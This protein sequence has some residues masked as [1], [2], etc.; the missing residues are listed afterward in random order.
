M[1]GKGR[2]LSPVIQQ[3]IKSGHVPK[4]RRWR[5][6]KTENLTTGEK[7]CRF[8]EMLRVPEGDLVG[9]RIRLL[10]F[11]AAFIQAI[12]DGPEG[13]ARLAILSVGRKAGK[14]T[15]TAALL[16]A[17]MFMR[18]MASQN[19]RV[20]SAALSREQAGLIYNYMAKMLQMT[21]E[22]E[23][24]YRLVPSSKRIVA[25]R[26]GIEYHALAA[27]AGKAMGLSP[28]V[29]VGDEWGQIPG[30]THPY[31][32][33][34]LTAQG[35][36]K[37]PLT[38]II[39]TQAPS[40][41]SMLSRMIDDAIAHPR[42]EVVCHLYA[43]DQECDLEDKKQWEKACPAI[44]SFRSFDDVKTQAAK[45]KRMPSDEPGFRNLILNQRIALVQLA[46]APTTWKQCRDPIDMGVFQRQRVIAG[47]DLSSRQDLT[48][49]VLAAEEDGVTHVLPLV[50]CPT[51]GILE[52]AQRDRAPYNTWV[53]HGQMLPIGGATMDFDQIAAATDHFIRA[54]GIHVAELHYDRHMIEHFKSACQR[55]GVFQ[56]TRWIDV[57]QHFKDM[58]VRLASLQGM[59][60]EQRIRHGGHPLLNMAAANAIAKLGRDGISALD[61]MNST[62]RIDPLVAMVMACWPFG[63]GRAES[64]DPAV[65]FG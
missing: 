8:I 57:P 58:G 35:A 53:Q 33:A 50:F 15:I 27:E 17:M 1:A 42:P 34:L 41:V 9:Q 54:N 45:A 11:Q 14:S 22:L 2:Q 39:S 4:M 60:A 43:A 13:W 29:L 12:F 40:D 20:N 49:I 3:A 26:T 63:D 47:C 48:A 64:F 10:D 55:V 65:A 6:M 61:K 23:G 56:G 7:V 62:Q 18:G 36:H 28:L 25:L 24:L 31:V 51:E 5:Q 30:E 21:D 37:N 19:A 32:D 59:L 46:V 16:I 52:R 44:G 38:V